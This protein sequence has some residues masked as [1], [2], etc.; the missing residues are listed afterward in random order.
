M[1][2]MKFPIKWLV[3]R[4]GMK[5]DVPE[6]PARRGKEDGNISHQERGEQS[7]K[8]S[9]SLHQEERGSNGEKEEK[10]RRLKKK[11]RKGPIGGKYH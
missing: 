9:T 8:N 1:I 7:G 3:H 4:V 10:N 6:R 11:N 5:A 2:G